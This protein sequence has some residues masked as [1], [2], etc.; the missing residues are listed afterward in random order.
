[1]KRVFGFLLGF[2]AWSVTA[3]PL[4]VVFL[5]VTNS[6]GEIVYLEPHFPYAHVVLKIENRFFHSHPQS[7]VAWVSSGD[8]ERYGNPKEF[9]DLGNKPWTDAVLVEV[10]GKPY[11]SHFSWSDERFYCS[12]LVAKV[13]GIQPE[14]MHFDPQIWP[15]S[16]QNLEGLPGMSPGKIY[17]KLKAGAFLFD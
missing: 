16:F 2:C 10:V 9:F 11:D 4:E 12:E 3:Q 14:P 15:P 8:L 17:E 13:L 6:Q 1:V 5:E 7:G